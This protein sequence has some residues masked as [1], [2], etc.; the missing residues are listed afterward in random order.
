MLHSAQQ[1][2]N[3][4]S[5]EFLTGV[6]RENCEKLQD[7][8]RALEFSYGYQ[9]LEDNLSDSDAVGLAGKQMYASKTARKKALAANQAD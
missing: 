9:T 1:C 5:P 2:P 3:R 8:P 7:L 4:R 6:L